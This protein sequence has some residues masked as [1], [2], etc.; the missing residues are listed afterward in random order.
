MPTV[1]VVG[2]GTMG[3]STALT[4]AHSEV[5]VLLNDISEQAMRRALETIEHE[6]CILMM[7]TEDE[8]YANGSQS[9][10]PDLIMSRITVEADFGKLGIADVVVENVTEDPGIKKSVHRQLDEIMSP[11][12]LF[13]I[14]TSCIPITTI[15]MDLAHAANS[16]GVH[17][18][19]PVPYSHVAEVIAGAHTTSATLRRADDLLATM[20]IAG[21]RAPDT[22]GFILN[23]MAMLLANEAATL[24]DAGVPA[25]DVDTMLVAGLGHKMGILRTIDLIGVRTVVRSLWVL[26]GTFGDRYRPCRP[27]ID[28]AENDD[29][30]F[31]Q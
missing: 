9:W 18:M 4:L 26:E 10:A 17:F 13:V 14:N 8:S 24:V 1:A 5:T 12:A 25:R 27:L 23:R 28:M 22:P 30:F 15:T 2:A 21:V 7:D 16:V 6:C 20:G 19:N 11:D 3:T 29:R 31:P